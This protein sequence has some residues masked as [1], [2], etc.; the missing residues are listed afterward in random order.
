MSLKI[1]YVL[2]KTCWIYP[3]PKYLLLNIFKMELIVFPTSVLPHSFPIRIEAPVFSLPKAKNLYSVL[4]LIFHIQMI[5]MFSS[6]YLSSYFSYLFSTPTSLLPV[7]PL[8]LTWTI[9]VMFL[10]ILL[11]NICWAPVCQALGIQ[12]Q[13]RHG[14]YFQ[15]TDRL[16]LICLHSFSC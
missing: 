6:F 16:V 2:C 8:S 3:L 12:R 7:S 5:T 9:A 15:K 14:N 11:T 13:I 1:V 10:Y 4:F